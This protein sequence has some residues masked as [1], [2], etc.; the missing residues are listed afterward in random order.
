[1]IL[2]DIHICLQAKDVTLKWKR[3]QKH[4]G[5]AFHKYWFSF[6]LECLWQQTAAATEVK[7]KK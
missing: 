2:N 1:M 7:S 5:N 3:K 4:I 6:R